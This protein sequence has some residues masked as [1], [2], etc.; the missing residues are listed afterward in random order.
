MTICWVFSSRCSGFLVAVAVTSLWV[1]LSLAAYGQASTASINGT[2]RDT[3]GAVVPR[4]ALVLRNVDTG[5]EKRSLTNDVG[6]YAYFN[7]V[8]GNYTLEA[9]TQGFTTQRLNAFT[10]VVNQVA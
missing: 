9:G 10:L 5:V 3:A 6:N 7:I 1:L 8:P 4:A 2:V